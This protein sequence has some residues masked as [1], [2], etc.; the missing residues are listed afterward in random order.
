MRTIL[1]IIGLMA[2]MVLEMRTERDRNDPHDEHDEQKRKDQRQPLHDLHRLLPPMLYSIK[3][4]AAQY[5]IP[6]KTAQNGTERKPES[7]ADG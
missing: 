5:S 4:V 1:L 6:V 2:A 7:A 3:R